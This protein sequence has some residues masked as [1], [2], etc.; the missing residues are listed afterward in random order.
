MK[1]ERE[2][3]EI[4]DAINVLLNQAYDSTLDEIH[5]LLKRIEEEEE[6]ADLKAYDEGMEDIRINGTVSWEEVKKEM[7]EIKKDVA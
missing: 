1:T 6:E 7:Q 2:R 5:A 3:Q 4:I